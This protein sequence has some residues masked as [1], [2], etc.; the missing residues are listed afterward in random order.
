MLRHT[1]LCVLSATAIAICVGC[2]TSTHENR[3]AYVARANLMPGATP[4]V[5]S[6][7][8]QNQ[9]EVKLGPERT[10]SYE[11]LESFRGRAASASKGGGKG[12][13]ASAR[14]KSKS[15]TGKKGPIGKLKEMFSNIKFNRGTTDAS[16]VDGDSPPGMAAPGRPSSPDDDDDA[17][18]D[19]D[20]DEDDEDEDDADEDEDNDADED[21]DDDADG[22]EDEDDDDEDDDDADD[23]EDD[24]EDVG[25]GEDPGLDPPGP[26]PGSGRGGAGG[27]RRRG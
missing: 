4:A 16:Q 25:G 3:R 24:D 12:A 18:D 14:S 17:D 7:Y 1:L 8:T 10:I 21:E 2:D 22:D 9:G 19:D 6:L 15:K 11:P 23:D 5:S 13:K 26:A 27:G 20:E